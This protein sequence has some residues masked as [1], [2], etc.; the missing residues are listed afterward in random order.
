MKSF[1]EEISQACTYSSVLVVDLMSDSDE[2]QPELEYLLEA[3]DDE[4]GLPPSGNSLGK[5][6]RDSSYS[7]G[8]GELWGFE[9]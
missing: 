7:S 3:S 8:I 5:L 4:L 2:S 6:G 1:K 9:D